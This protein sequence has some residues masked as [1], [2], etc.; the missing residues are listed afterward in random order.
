MPK[1]TSMAEARRWLDTAD[2]GPLQ[3]TRGSAHVMG[4]CQMGADA[5]AGVV[6]SHGRHFAIENLSI[7]DGSIFPT[8]I[9]ANPSVSIYATA[10]RN[11]RTLAADLA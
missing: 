11:A 9:G 2:L 4:G 3:L 7:H 10:L 1:L 8:S 6:D 5:K